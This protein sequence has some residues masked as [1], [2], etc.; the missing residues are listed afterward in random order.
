MR[1]A[2]PLGAK[3]GR[4]AGRIAGREDGAIAGEE[5]AAELLVALEPP[6]PAPGTP[7]STVCV[8]YQDYVP[9]V[10]YVPPVAPGE[11]AAP[12]DCPPGQVPVGTTGACGRPYRRAGG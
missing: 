11:T 8:L 4:R 5:D 3:E 12:I 6:E 1:R 9:G 2:K 7:G 10:G